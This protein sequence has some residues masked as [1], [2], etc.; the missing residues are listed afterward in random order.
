MAINDGTLEFVPVEGG[1]RGRRKGAI[2]QERGCEIAYGQLGDGGRLVR[3]KIKPKKTKAEAS[4]FYSKTL[5]ELCPCPV[6]VA[7]VRL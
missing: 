3:R 2:V 4:L 7:V 6:V 1:G 5:L